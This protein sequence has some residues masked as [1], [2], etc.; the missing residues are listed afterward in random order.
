[1]INS[2]NHKLII[3]LVDAF[4]YSRQ[5]ILILELVS[6]GEL[7]ER[8]MEDELISEMDVT[9]YIKQVLQAVR[10]MHQQEILHLDLK[11]II[12]SVN[13]STLYYAGII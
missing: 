10:H 7:F 1:M 5:F 12:F 13:F 9:Y 2:L 11:V 6:G 3:N 8:L 4:E